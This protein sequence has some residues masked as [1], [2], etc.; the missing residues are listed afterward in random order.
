MTYFL[1]TLLDCISGY[2]YNGSTCLSCLRPLFGSGSEK[3]VDGGLSTRFILQQPQ[4]GAHIQTSLLVNDGCRN[5]PNINLNIAVNI[6]TGCFELLRLILIEKPGATCFKMIKCQVFS[7][8]N[9]EG[10]RVCG[11]GCPCADSAN[12][13]LIHLISDINSTDVEISEVMKTNWE[14]WF[15]FWIFMGTGLVKVRLTFFNRVFPQLP[16]LTFLSFLYKINITGFQNHKKK[17]NSTGYWT[18]NTNPTLRFPAPLTT[19]PPRHLLNRRFMNWTLI[20]SGLI[21]HD[22][23]RVW[24]F[25]AGMD[26]ADWLSG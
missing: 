2:I 25:E 7:S 22:F 8:V 12:Q 4:D 5:G 6:D 15:V 3:L 20:I 17:I 16:D 10:H 14:I 26:C 13:C 18:H 24:K 1:S 11:I 21:E 19:Q 9:E 23:K